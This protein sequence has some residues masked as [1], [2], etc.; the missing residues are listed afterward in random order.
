MKL[1]GDAC[2]QALEVEGSRLTALGA[3]CACTRPGS[4]RNNGFGIIIAKTR[5]ACVIAVIWLGW[6]MGRERHGLKEIVVMV[7]E[8][9][10]VQMG[11]GQDGHVS[12]GSLNIAS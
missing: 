11:K 8:S 4:R 7:D 10:S 5:G 6:R 3:V 9:A 12:K 2:A 1:K